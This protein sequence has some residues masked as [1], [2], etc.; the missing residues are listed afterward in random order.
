ME[1]FI[2][3]DEDLF[4]GRVAGAVDL[5]RR[6]RR[7]LQMKDQD[8]PPSFLCPHT[9]PPRVARHQRLECGAL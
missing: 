5:S 1:R 6:L 4:G 2:V 9:H 3:G 7:A 8:D